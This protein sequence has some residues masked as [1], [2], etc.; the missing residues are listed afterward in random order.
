M[1]RSSSG[2]TLNPWILLFCR[3]FLLLFSSL[4]LLIRTRAHSMIHSRAYGKKSFSSRLFTWMYSHM[5]LMSFS[6]TSSEIIKVSISEIFLLP[7]FSSRGKRF[8]SKIHNWWRRFQANQECTHKF[9][10]PLSVPS[11]DVTNFYGTNIFL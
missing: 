10:N 1:N 9:I 7:F 6:L 5:Y 3:Q 2:K 8:F 4:T 11:F